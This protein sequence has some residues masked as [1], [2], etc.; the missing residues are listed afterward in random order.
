LINKIYLQVQFPALSLGSVWP[1]VLPN[2]TLA[3]VAWTNSLG[4]A[5]IKAVTIEVGGQKIDSQYGEWLEIW[6]ALTQVAEKENGY[7]HMIGKYAS[8]V[9]LIGNADSS[10]IYY[11]PLMFWFNKNPGLSLPLIALQYHEV[12]IVLEF[13]HAAELIVGLTSSGDRDFGSNT[14][15]I[16]D[17]AGVSLVNAALWVNYVYLD[18]EERRRFAQMSHEYLIDQ[19]QFTGFE[20]LQLDQVSQ[21]IRLN[22]NHP[23]KEIIWTLQWE[24]NF[25]VGTAYNDWFNFSAALPGVPTPSYAVDLMADALIMLNGH[26]R[27]AVRPQTYFRLVQPYECHTRIPDNFIYLYSFG[28]RPEEHQPSGTVNMSRIDNAQLKFDLTN[29]ANLPPGSWSG[30]I[31]RI[32]IYATNYNVFRVMSGMGGLAYSN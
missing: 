10:R 15:S 32:A 12:K 27:F 31:G 24:P 1:D 30:A 5:L 23:V 4:H 25:T 20:S 18:T 29:V 28:L 13:R 19:L 22:Y 17:S 3:S 9:G 6:N 2:A 26:E 16:R 21:K 8:S 14:T 7:N 11:I